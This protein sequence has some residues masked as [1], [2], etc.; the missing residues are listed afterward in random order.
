M[1]ISIAVLCILTALSLAGPA[2]AQLLRSFNS[3]SAPDSVVSS[4]LI[5]TVGSRSG[6]LAP[7][8]N[9]RRLEPVRTREGWRDSGLARIQE[10]KA[11]AGRIAIGA[12]LGLVAG[13]A[14]GFIHGAAGHP[15]LP[16]TG[17]DVPSELEYTPFFALG[18]AIVGGILGAR[19][20]RTCGA[21]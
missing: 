19:P 6:L 13:A 4:A 20:P 11:S 18:G 10:C 21:A 16:H 3:D 17:M 7:E 5:L 14:V 12:T 2:R 8:F 15:G 9:S 1:R